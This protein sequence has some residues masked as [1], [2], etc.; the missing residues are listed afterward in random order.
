MIIFAVLFTGASQVFVN[1]ISLG[2]AD[3]L[4]GEEAEDKI[5]KKVK[6]LSGG[7]K[8]RVAIARTLMKNPKIIFCDEIVGSLDENNSLKIMKYIKEISKDILVINISHNIKLVNKFSDYVISLETKKVDFISDFSIII[9][10]LY[11]VKEIKKILVKRGDLLKC[12]KTCS[13]P[14]GCAIRC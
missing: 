4:S 7:E 1:S 14:C 2:T 11:R 6:L 12:T 9:L 8:Q 3:S 13:S 10:S 5:N